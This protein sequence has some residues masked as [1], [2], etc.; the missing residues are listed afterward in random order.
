MAAASTPA[1]EIVVT[2]EDRYLFDLQ[3]FLMLRGAIAE[4]DQREMLAEIER[5][6]GMEFD[7]SRFKQHVAGKKGDPTKMVIDGAYVRLNSLFRISDAFDRLID[8]P[9]VL[10]YLKAFINRPQLANGWVISKFAGADYGGWHRGVSPEQYTVRHGRINTRMLNSVYFLTDNGPDDGC[11]AVIPGGHKSNFDLPWNNYSGVKLPGSIR[12]TGKP[13]D[14]L[15]FSEALLH[16]GLPKTTQGRRTNVYFN[17]IAADFN[18]MTYSPQHN[19]NFAMPPSVRSR[20]T[21]QRKALTE[22]MEYV[23]TEE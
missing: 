5:L 2:D 17:Y 20:L 3:G 15:I 13:G 22:W 7:D 11:M 16:T 12:V 1:T 4:Q 19:R 8:Y 6:E 23:Q 10:P 9:T 21:E 18:V 14:V